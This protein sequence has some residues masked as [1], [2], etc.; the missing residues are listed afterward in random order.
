MLQACFWHENRASDVQ[1]TLKT[2]SPGEKLFIVL[3]SLI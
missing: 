2:S 1:V 3:L